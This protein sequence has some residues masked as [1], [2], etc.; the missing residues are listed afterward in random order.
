[1]T[2]LMGTATVLAATACISFAAFAQD[3][4][5]VTWWYESANPEQQAALSSLLIEKFDAASAGHGAVSGN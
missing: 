5:P 4:A 1:M 2:K 3:K